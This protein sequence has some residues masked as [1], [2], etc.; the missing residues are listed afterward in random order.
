MA[1]PTLHAC[2]ASR[3]FFP[4]LDYNDIR[5]HPC[6]SITF[7]FWFISVDDHTHGYQLLTAH[8]QNIV[9]VFVN[10]LYFVVI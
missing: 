7:G 3:M 9:S 5:N 1:M 8:S 2:G 4:L 10:S 6:N